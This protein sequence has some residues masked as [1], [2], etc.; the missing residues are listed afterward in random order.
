MVTTYLTEQSF[1]ARLNVSNTQYPGPVGYWEF[2]AGYN[3]RTAWHSS[4]WL[5]TSRPDRRGVALWFGAVARAGQ[6][7]AYDIRLCTGSL[8]SPS[9]SK[10]VDISTNGYLGFYGLSSSVGPLWRLEPASASRKYL[11][12]LDGKGVGIQRDVAFWTSGRK[13]HYLCVGVAPSAEFEV[14]I[15]RM[16]VAPPL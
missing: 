8:A 10:R 5:T 16:A 4:D 9:A 2:S 12:T 14:E 7:P 15:I 13:G 1:I 11:K 3:H 6:P